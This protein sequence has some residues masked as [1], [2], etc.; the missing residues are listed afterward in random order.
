MPHRW[1]HFAAYSA[2]VSLLSSENRRLDEDL[3]TTKEY[4]KKIETRL[5][6]GSN[7]Q[8]SA[9]VQQTSCLVLFAFTSP[10]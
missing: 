2:Q 3:T 4:C 5:V 10:T 9:V 8:V 6:H 1:L 7:G